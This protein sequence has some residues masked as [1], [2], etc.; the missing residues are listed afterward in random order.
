MWWNKFS[1]IQYV[2]KFAL[3]ENIS[4][5]ICVLTTDREWN[6]KVFCKAASKRTIQR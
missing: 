5:N 6:K 1:D 4:E 2:W 3:Y